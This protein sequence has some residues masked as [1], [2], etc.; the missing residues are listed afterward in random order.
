[1]S[2]FIEISGGGLPQRLPLSGEITTI[3]RD[4]TNT[5]S[6]RTDQSVS[7]F[8]SAIVEYPGG[9]CVRDVGSSNGTFVNNK[10]VEGDQHLRSGDEILLGDVVL[11]FHDDGAEDL[12]Q[13]ITWKK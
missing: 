4:T 10:R 1:M 11:V 8:H 13:T 3:G 9:Y 6:L 5:I 12:E 7:R 2:A